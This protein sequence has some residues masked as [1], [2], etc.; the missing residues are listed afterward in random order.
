MNTN[1]NTNPIAVIHTPHSSS[2]I[3]EDIR[4]SI[5]LSDG[6]LEEELV[7]VTDAYTDNLFDC[8]SS[9][10][11]KIIFPVSRLVVDPERFLDDAAEPM[12]KVGMGVIYTRTSA[13]E[14]L[15]QPPSE[16]ERESLIQRYYVPHHIRLTEAV[17]EAVAQYGKCL[18]IDCHSFPSIPLP[19]ELDKT[20]Y[21]PDICIGTDDY[22]TPLWLS[23]LAQNIFTNAGFSVK[24]NSPYSG[25]IVPLPYYHSNDKVYSVLIEINRRLYMDEVTG[26]RN[27]QFQKLRNRLSPNLISL[28]EAVMNR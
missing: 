24:I 3:P 5:K 13:G 9:L 17:G 2:N 1:T 15:R 27:N 21:R 25:A 6:E 14:M 20:P 28:I 26:K 7:C 10:A 8:P 16:G 19:H 12:S 18:I 4:H 11:K 23:D 22:H